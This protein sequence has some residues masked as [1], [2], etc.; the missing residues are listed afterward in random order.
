MKN[1]G[2]AIVLSSLFILN[3]CSVL[4]FEFATSQDNTECLKND[5]SKKCT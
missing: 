5:P 2:L 4:N 3:G 1:I